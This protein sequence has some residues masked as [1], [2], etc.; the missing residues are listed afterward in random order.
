MSIT[1]CIV[2]H[3][4]SSTKS[5]TP[6]SSSNHGAAWACTPE[7]TRMTLPDT[8]VITEL[9]AELCCAQ[10]NHIPGQLQSSVAQRVHPERLF[11]RKVKD[12]VKKWRDGRLIIFDLN[13]MVAFYYTVQYCTLGGCIEWWMAGWMDGWVDWWVGER[14]GGR[15]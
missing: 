4:G 2:Q 1:Y 14:L 9:S 6:Q 8:H 15:K 7:D 13:T 12:G 5:Q 10:F 3:W 11:R